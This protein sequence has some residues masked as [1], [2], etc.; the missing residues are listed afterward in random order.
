MYFSNLNEFEDK[1][2]RVLIMPPHSVTGE[3]YCFPCRQLIFGLRVNQK[4]ML[5]LKFLMLSFPEK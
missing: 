5:I 2:P 3:V 4:L 1:L